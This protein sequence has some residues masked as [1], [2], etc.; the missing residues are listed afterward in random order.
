MNKARHRSV[1]TLV[2]DDSLSDVVLLRDAVDFQAFDV[3]LEVIHDGETALRLMESCRDSNES[4][5]DLII[6]DLNLP[7]VNGFEILDFLKKDH[8]LRAVPVIVMSSSSAEQDVRRAY[9]LGANA[10]VVKPISL[11]EVMSTIR[12]LAEFWFRTA[13]LLRENTAEAPRIP[14]LGHAFGH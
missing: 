3:S 8:R 6:L 14:D 5:A 2:I 13:R 1:R 11:G 10:Y 4:P 12:A 9:L 7:K